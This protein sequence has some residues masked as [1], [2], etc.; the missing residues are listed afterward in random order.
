MP[1]K[2]RSPSRS[3]CARRSKRQAR[4]PRWS[5]PDRALA[6]RVAAALERWEVKVDDSGGDCAGRHAGRR[7]RA[8]RA[9]KPRS[10]AWR[11]CRCWRCSSIRCCGSAPR[12]ARTYA[13][14][15]ALERAVLRGPRPRPGSDGAWPK[16]F[17]DVPRQSRRAAPQ[18]S[19]R[20]DRD[21]E[22]RRRR[23]TDRPAR[24]RAGAAGN[25]SKPGAHPL[26]ALAARHSAI[27]V[28]A[29][30]RMTTATSPPSPTMTAVRS[31]APSKNS[32]TA[33]PPPASPSPTTDY[34]ELFHAIIAD[35]VVR[36]PETPDVRVRIFGPLE[37]RL[38][39]VDRIVLGGLNEGTWPPE[40]RSDPWLSRPMR[41]DLGL[42]PPERR[43]GLSAH[44][45]AQA[46]GR[47]EVILVARR[48][49]RRRADGG[50][51]LRAAHRRA[52]RRGALERGR[53]RAATSISSYARALDHPA[54]SEIRRAPGA[55]AATRGA[56][57]RLSVT[58]IE[59]WLR[60]PYT[61]YAKHMLAPACRSMRSTR[62]PARRPRHRHPRRHRRFHQNVRRRTARRSAEGT[63][64]ARRE[65]FRHA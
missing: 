49:G 8:A 5:T 56:A 20:A 38:Q 48:Q 37:A 32:S 60:D 44:D 15:A 22:L 63:A 35:R 53:S 1:R 9:R 58:E 36:R 28:A 29:L 47:R 19:A 10:A 17:R 55:D 26:A 4:P 33:R 18:R 57:A 24:R 7:V 46:L 31:P 34:A 39:T 54:P 25:L 6:R 41:R 40:T 45:F 43:I 59:D 16:R 64:R 2:K 27:I 62:R 11:R 21:D 14:I 12:R 61:I 42:D 52:R 65:A 50:L 30:G 13:A 23:R 51:A 3:P